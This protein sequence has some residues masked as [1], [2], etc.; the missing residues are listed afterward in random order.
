[1]RALEL[2]LF[3][4]VGIASELPSG[5]HST[6]NLDHEEFFRLL[7]ARKETY[8]KLPA[9]RFDAERYVLCVIGFEDNL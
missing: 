7:L 8:E 1:M 4:K 9:D 3:R 2:T 5:E 6:S